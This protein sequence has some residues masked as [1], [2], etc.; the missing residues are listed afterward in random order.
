M[1]RTTTTSE[2]FAWALNICLCSGAPGMFLDVIPEDG[3]LREFD[4]SQDDKLGTSLERIA[5]SRVKGFGTVFR[6]HCGNHTTPDVFYV[7]VAHAVRM[8]K[9]H[10]SKDSNEAQEVVPKPQAGQHVVS[11]SV[12]SREIQTN[13]QVDSP[14]PI[15]SQQ[16]LPQQQQQSTRKEEKEEKKSSSIISPHI[17]IVQDID[18]APP[19]TLE[20]LTEM[21][22]MKSLSAPPGL[23]NA[24]VPELLQ[25]PPHF[26]VIAT[27]SSL[28]RASTTT[29]F[30][31]SPSEG[32]ISDRLMNAFLLR[33]PILLPKSSPQFQRIERLSR[34]ELQTLI[35]AV[36][37]VYI[38]PLIIKHVRDTVSAVRSHPYVACGL[39]PRAADSLCL[40]IRVQAAL[41]GSRFAIPQDFTDCVIEAFA[42]RFI[43]APAEVLPIELTEEDPVF[44]ARWILAAAVSSLPVIR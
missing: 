11:F 23:T 31:T 26:I 20:C 10:S 28:P 32:R 33:I 14:S 39:P 35:E 44:L 36:P 7:A 27:S 3:I 4:S 37:K 12:P 29:N 5:E 40:A 34:N 30:L 24:V 42:H 43:V 1:K 25:L 17:F 13:M 38:S 8:Q 16:L 41:R 9:E 21:L 2:Y 15:S 18:R 22:I 19:R 6:V